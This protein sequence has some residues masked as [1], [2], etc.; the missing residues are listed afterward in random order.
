ML[1][2]WAV[3]GRADRSWP[4]EHPERT[5]VGVLRGGGGGPERTGWGC[6]A[7]DDDLSKVVSLSHV[8]LFLFETTSAR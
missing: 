6:V 7:Q 8:T 4:D 1:Q 5:G 3:K 2:G